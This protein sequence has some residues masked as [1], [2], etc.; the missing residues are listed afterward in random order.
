M[1]SIRTLLAVVVAL[2]LIICILVGVLVFRK[3]ADDT[4]ETES[5]IPK[6]TESTVNNQSAIESATIQDARNLYVE[7][8]TSVDYANGAVAAQNL[9]IKANEK[10]VLIID[11]AVSS[12]VYDTYAEAQAVVNAHIVEASAGTISSTAITWLA[13]T[14]GMLL[15]IVT[16]TT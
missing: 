12:T 1:T 9:I 8:I 2:L 3:S 14:D 7:Y 13:E 4:D 6:T 5:T 15:P 10:Y 11:G 16:P